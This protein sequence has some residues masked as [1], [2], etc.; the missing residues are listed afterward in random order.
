MQM[1]SA[2]R[3]QRLASSHWLTYALCCFLLVACTP[4]KQPSSAAKPGTSLFCIN[5]ASYAGKV[6]GDGECV[7]LIKRCS[8]APD[9]KFWRAG[10]NV[11]SGPT[12]KSGTIIATFKNG[13]YP[14]ATGYH[15]AIYI[16]HN[17]DGIWVWDQ[18]RG[19]AVHKRLIRTRKDR[20]QSN[21]KAQHYQ[22]VKVAGL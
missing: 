13:R 19:K 8:G 12:L 16:E 6:V 2:R 1:K 17:K 11:I 5:A 14:N 7:S 9:T 18:W 4:T 20:A 10:E 22:V 15:A 3:A 21:N